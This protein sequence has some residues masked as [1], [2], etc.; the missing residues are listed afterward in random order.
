MLR[1]M[2]ILWPSFL[3]AVVGVGLLFSMLDPDELIVFGHSLAGERMAAYTCGFF[4]LW[5]LCASAAATSVWLC[6]GAADEGR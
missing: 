2:Q 5:A 4:I 6:C 3:M 1:M